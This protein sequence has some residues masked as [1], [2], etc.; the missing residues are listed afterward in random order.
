MTTLHPFSTSRESILPIWSVAAQSRRS[1]PDSRAAD[2]FVLLHG[3]LFTNIQ[4][5]DFQPT[6]ARFMERLQLEG[7]EEREWIMMAVVN[8]AAVLEYGKPT[9]ILRSTGGIG[10]GAGTKD[11]STA[12]QAAAATAKVNMLVK[13]V[14]EME[15]D[16]DDE[17]ATKPQPIEEDEIDVKSNGILNVSPMLSQSQATTS[18]E[19]AEPPLSFKFALQL[20]FEMFA[21]TLRNPFRKAT[22]FSHPTINPYNTVV[23]TFLSTVLKNAAVQRV[24]ERAIPWGDMAAFFC[25]VPRSIVPQAEGGMRLTAGCS[26]LS[27]DWCLRGMEWGGRRV[28]ERGFWKGGEERRAEMEI[29]DSV[30]YKDGLTDGII[31]DE[32][33]DENQAEGSETNKRWVRIVRGAA[34]I[35]KV[36]PGFKWEHGSR[37]FS[38]VGELE[39]K[40]K[41]WKEDDRLAREEE[42]RRRSRRPWDD[43]MDIDDEGTLFDELDEE[44]SDDDADETDEVKA[45]KVLNIHSSPYQSAQSNTLF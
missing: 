34:G 25:K 13:K 6:L 1:A 26:P 10:S 42:E 15:V 27:E 31:E 5:D 3:M 16:D 14:D 7:A 4:L 33:E 39:E 41:R 2:L 19:Q 40:V 36:V 32:D 8:I 43:G 11:T 23:L 21:Y 17:N 35:A 37:N 18:E 12:A 45:L 9:G 22:P 24:L 20:T 29:L 28:Y 38:V 30:E 44:D